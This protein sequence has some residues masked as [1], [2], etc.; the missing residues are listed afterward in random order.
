MEES[1]EGKQG[2]LHRR[3]DLHWSR[4]EHKYLGVNFHDIEVTT[5]TTKT[6]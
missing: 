3:S 4:L 5:L 1:W 6:D 2:Y